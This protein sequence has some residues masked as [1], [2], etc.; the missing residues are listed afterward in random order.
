MRT[1]LVLYAAISLCLAAPE[2]QAGFLGARLANAE[3]GV[4][5][6]RVIP[7]TPA[8]AAGLVAN[9][10]IVS[11]GGEKV[12]TAL[13]LGTKLRAAGAGT[14]VAIEILRGTEKKTF[15]VTLGVHPR[16][17]REKP[18]T[19]PGMLAVTVTRD[20]DMSSIQTNKHLQVK[21]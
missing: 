20:R 3:G 21:I 18:D 6:V 4:R 1:A 13:D 10:V 8:A 9:D 12:A 15:T 17:L 7:E 14:S 5:L 11:I 19:S 2:R 16:V